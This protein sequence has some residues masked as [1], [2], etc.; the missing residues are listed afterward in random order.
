MTPPYSQAR[1]LLDDSVLEET[2]G[3]SSDG[4]LSG[5]GECIIYLVTGPR[6]VD[7]I[8]FSQIKMIQ[9]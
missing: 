9:Q 7:I 6:L 8:Y 2:C 1:H 5:V 3:A 4:S